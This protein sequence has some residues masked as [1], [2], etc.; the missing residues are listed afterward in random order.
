MFDGKVRWWM[1]ASGAV[2]LLLVIG[3][4]ALSWRTHHMEE[5]LR[6]MVERELSERF[7]SKVELKAL[8]VHIF[9]RVGVVGEGL[10]L[11]HHSRRDIPPL[12]Q[13]ERFSFYTGLIGLIRPTKHIDVVHL[14][15]L[16]ITLPPHGNKGKQPQQEENQKPDKSKLLKTILDKIVCHD[17]DI[18]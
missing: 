1:V 5:Y 16:Q 10:T 17:A 4:V 7:Q 2:A 18:F 15:K 3:I 12:I 13:V 14:D 6:V 8:H 11:R 9:P